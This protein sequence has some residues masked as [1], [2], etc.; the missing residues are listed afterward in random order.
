MIWKFYYT[1][2]FL[3]LHDQCQH[4]YQEVGSEVS[5]AS[6]TRCGSGLLGVGASGAVVVLLEHGVV[7]IGRHELVRVHKVVQV[8]R[9]IVS[10]SS[11]CYRD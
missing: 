9:A 8:L 3:H 2:T 6:D 11:L 7:G 1:D 10:N 5:H 4:S